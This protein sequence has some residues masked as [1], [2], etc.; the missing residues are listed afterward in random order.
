MRLLLDTS[1]LI[2]AAVEPA[3]LSPLAQREIA[4]AGNDLGISA[5]S[6][7]EVAQKHRKGK[8]PRFSPADYRHAVKMLRLSVMA[9][10]EDHALQAGGERHP[11]NDPWDRMIAA[12]SR[13]ENIAVLTPDSEIA[14][15]GGRVLW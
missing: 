15:L 10:T 2:F 8:L 7:Y 12:Q 9:V 6:A 4:D 5:V 13:I 1:T 14:A 11:H 3:R